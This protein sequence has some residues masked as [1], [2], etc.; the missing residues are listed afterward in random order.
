MIKILTNLKPYICLSFLITLFDFLTKKWIIDNMY[1]HEKKLLISCLNLKYENNYG[2]AFSLLDKYS[3]LQRW[4]IIF[5]IISI[6]SFMFIQLYHSQNK[7]IKIAFSMMI[8]GAIGNLINRI[9]HGF[10]IDFID[11]HIF[12]WHFATFNFADTSI[13]IGTFIL[14]KNIFTK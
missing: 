13:C 2:I 1:L 6:I 4:S 3:I 9:Y 12:N 8:G 11:F 14:I 10:V 5:I 7:Y